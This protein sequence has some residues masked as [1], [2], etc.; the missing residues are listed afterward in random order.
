M[1]IQRKNRQNRING[2]AKINNLPISIP[3]SPLSGAMDSVLI[4]PESDTPPQFCGA[5]VNVTRT[6]NQSAIVDPRL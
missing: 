1:H 5:Q 2:K 6:G 3:L 4:E